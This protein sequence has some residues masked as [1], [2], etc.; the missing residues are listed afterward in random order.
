MYFNA[1]ATGDTNM[2]REIISRNQ[3]ITFLGNKDSGKQAI[4]YSLKNRHLETTVF[5]TERGQ[6]ISQSD[7]SRILHNSSNPYLDYQFC[8]ELSQRL[9]TIDGMISSVFQEWAFKSLKLA[10]FIKNDLDSLEDLMKSVGLSNWGEILS[11]YREYRKNSLN[12][13]TKQFIR[14]ITLKYLLDGA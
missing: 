12:P 13:K 14:D 2:V 9:G 7:I 1:A 11:E 10:C 3:N 6:T 5:L 8:I 4:F